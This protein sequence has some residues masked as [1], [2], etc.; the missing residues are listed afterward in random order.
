MI[1]IR[2]SEENPRG[3]LQFRS[4]NLPNQS[5]TENLIGNRDKLGVIVRLQATQHARNQ[6]NALP[7]TVR[8]G[9]VPQYKISS[10]DVHAS[11]FCG[12][13]FWYTNPGRQQFLVKECQRSFFWFPCEETFKVFVDYVLEDLCPELTERIWTK[14]S[15]RGDHRKIPVPIHYLPVSGDPSQEHGVIV[16]MDTMAPFIEGLLIGK[17]PKTADSALHEMDMLRHVCIAIPLESA[18]T[19]NSKPV[20]FDIERGDDPTFPFKPDANGVVDFGAGKLRIGVNLMVFYNFWSFYYTQQFQMGIYLLQS[21]FRLGKPGLFENEVSK[22]SKKTP[23]GGYKSQVISVSEPLQRSRQSSNADENSTLSSRGTFERVGFGV[24]AGA[25]AGTGGNG[26]RSSDLRN[27]HQSNNNGSNSTSYGRNNSTGG[28][29]SQDNWNHYGNNGLGSSSGNHSGTKRQRDQQ[30]ELDT[31]RQGPGVPQDYGATFL[32]RSREDENDDND[33]NPL[34]QSNQLNQSAS[35]T[36]ASNRTSSSFQN[37]SGH[38]H[39]GNNNYSNNRSVFHYNGV[40]GDNRV[41]NHHNGSTNNGNDQAYGTPSSLNQTQPMWNSGNDP[42]RS[43]VS[44]GNPVQLS[45]DTN[46]HMIFKPM[47]FYDVT[48]HQSIAAAM[49]STSTIQIRQEVSLPTHTVQVS[50]APQLGQQNNLHVPVSNPTIPTISNVR[51]TP[52]VQQQLHEQDNKV[53]VY[54]PC[55]G[56][57]CGHCNPLQ[58]TTASIPR[59]RTVY[60]AGFTAIKYLDYLRTLQA[61]PQEIADSFAT[62]YNTLVVERMRKNPSEP[63]PIL[64]HLFFFLLNH[65]IALESE[66]T[67]QPIYVKREPIQLRPLGMTWSE[68]DE[69]EDSPDDSIDQPKRSNERGNDN[70][71]NNERNKRHHSA[72]GQDSSRNGNERRGNG[73]RNSGSSNPPPPPPP[74]D[75]SDNDDDENDDDDDDNDEHG[76]DNEYIEAEEYEEEEEEPVNARQNRNRSSRERAKKRRENQ[77]Q[78]SAPAS[79][80]MRNLTSPLFNSPQP[81]RLTEISQTTNTSL[82]LILAGTATSNAANRMRNQTALLREY[83]PVTNHDLIPKV[84][85]AIPMLNSV[86]DMSSQLMTLLSV[87]QL[88]GVTKWTFMTMLRTGTQ[89]EKADK[90][91]PKLNFQPIERLH[92]FVY[93]NDVVCKEVQYDDAESTIQL[94]IRVLLEIY[95]KIFNIPIDSVSA[96]NKLHSIQCESP[97]TAVKMI[98]QMI[99]LLHL[100]EGTRKEIDELLITE[101][102]RAFTQYDHILQRQGLFS[103]L[104]DEVRTRSKSIHEEYARNSTVMSGRELLLLATLEIES[105]RLNRVIDRDENHLLWLKGG[106]KTHTSDSIIQRNSDKIKLNTRHQ[107]KN[108]KFKLDRENQRSSTTERSFVNSSL[109]PRPTHIDKSDWNPT[110]ILHNSGNSPLVNAMTE[111]YHEWEKYAQDSLASNRDSQFIHT[112]VEYV[113]N[114]GDV[115]EIAE[116]LDM[117]LEGL[118]L[119]AQIVQSTLQISDDMV[120]RQRAWEAETKRQAS[121]QR[122]ARERE[123]NAFKQAGREA[124]TMAIEE[125]F[126][127]LAP[128]DDKYEKDDYSD[129]EQYIIGNQSYKND[130]YSREFG[131]N[132]NNKQQKVTYQSHQSRP[133][134]NNRQVTAV[135]SASR[136]PTPPDH[137]STCGQ[138]RDECVSIAPNYKDDNGVDQCYLRDDLHGRVNINVVSLDML[139][140]AEL[141][142]QQIEKVI[143]SAARYG[144]LHGMSQHDVEKLK[145]RVPKSKEAIRQQTLQIKNDM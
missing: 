13:E 114:D 143:N 22:M 104:V 111:K 130:R 128:S 56:M 37:Q 93:A 79:D 43:Q 142:Q 14:N 110:Q 64:E 140:L 124:A 3:T 30:E 41:D 88:I 102:F 58:P 66:A 62:V 127:G 133:P 112:F 109:V 92:T 67:E 59:T 38:H 132:N 11:S 34:P 26:I 32:R 141:P 99:E 89:L 6:L 60:I 8:S 117:E 4:P 61:I 40:D 134:Y 145:S 78:P 65:G 33:G 47:P 107:R 125:H 55:P 90:F 91:N 52:T 139:R 25:G 118:E 80:S 84:K 122:I 51:P 75:H 71:S 119:T 76:N 135:Q 115:A 23:T 144:C 98:Q 70:R 36:G 68:Y 44:E 131:N 85:P 83:H 49:E 113:V 95:L 101:A 74:G 27:L 108:L 81:S 39:S 12:E 10:K 100:V 137:C 77:R 121:E 1:P 50:T 16:K 120:E 29:G 28:N 105:D 48:Q 86:K 123:I 96:R 57:I 19:I 9:E 129:S 126:K 15:T 94:H 31:T 72:F 54:T 42:M 73:N 82:Q 21:P 7:H 35:T 24:G 136:A 2:L 97:E 87:C 46:N 106:S 69:L 63:F 18:L 17:A 53:C 103:N 138:H 20:M 116:E 45:I 5:I